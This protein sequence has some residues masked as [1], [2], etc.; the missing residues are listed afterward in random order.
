MSGTKNKWL[1]TI[2]SLKLG[3]VLLILIALV[4]ITGTVILQKPLAD[5]GQLER[6]YSPTKL[7]IYEA[8]GLLDLFH[9]RWFTALLALL[10]INIAAASVIRF[11]VAWREVRRHRQPDEELMRAMPL[12]QVVAA[13][14]E[15]VAAA[16]RRQHYRVRTMQL[17]DGRT[18]LTADKQRYAR[19]APYF[20]HFS[21]LI[22]LTGG[23]IDSHFGYRAFMRLTQGEQKS[24]AQRMLTDEPVSLPFAVRCD[25]AGMEQYPDGTPKRYWSKLVALEDGREVARK[26]IEVNSPLVHRG[27]RFFQSS[28]GRSGQLQRARLS[29][30]PKSP[31]EMQ[32]AKGDSPKGDSPHGSMAAKPEAAQA[33][34]P[35]KWVELN[36]SGETEIP[37][38]GLRVR[39]AAFFPD[40]YMDGNQIASRS[41]EP[42]NPALRLAVTRGDETVPV[43]VFAN[44]PQFSNTKNLPVKFGFGLDDVELGY[45][46]GLQVSSEPGQWLVWLGSTVLAFG[47]VWAFFFAHRQ[48][49]AIEMAAGSAGVPPA[50]HPRTKT[51][52]G[53]TPALPGATLL[54]G[55]TSK[56]HEDFRTEFGE[57]SES[58][59][60][61]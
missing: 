21:L 61:N 12:H 16:L 37:D 52:A 26:E 7:K 34:G 15:E 5:P 31:E 17:P 23:I 48:F 58:L 14:V 38:Y 41:D 47:F 8:L 40:F 28:F 35:V 30:M 29:V 57:L 13:P 6:V 49:W 55:M 54:A 56:N 51:E 43:W 60:E 9:T 19:L 45:F 10:M 36:S 42:N 11:P 24:S 44:Y 3:I 59:K 18:A 1:H 39:V 32:P 53:E 25:G 4:V 27:L 33:A 46:T 2:G 20:V 50:A 22:I